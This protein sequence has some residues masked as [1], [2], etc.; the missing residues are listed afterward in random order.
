MEKHTRGVEQRPAPVFS[1]CQPSGRFPSLLHPLVFTLFQQPQ[2]LSLS[3]SLSSLA[4]LVSSLILFLV[5]VVV[6]APSVLYILLGSVLFAA[7]RSHPR[8][9]DLFRTA[10]GISPASRL[11]TLCELKRRE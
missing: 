1:L 3:L 9:F 11:S 5:V 2:P 7:S 6:V 4:F 10:A 8:R